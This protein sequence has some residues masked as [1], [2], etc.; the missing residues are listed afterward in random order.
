MGKSL[1][2]TLLCFL[3]IPCSFFQKHNVLQHPIL[4]HLP[5]S[6]SSIFSNMIISNTYRI[7]PSRMVSPRLAFILVPPLARWPGHSASSGSPERWDF[8]GWK[9]FFQSY[10]QTFTSLLAWGLAFILVGPRIRD[11]W[12]WDS[13]SNRRGPIKFSKVNNTENQESN[14]QR[15]SPIHIL[16]VL[17]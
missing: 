13:L 9:K 14:I 1:K 2:K 3:N 16:T 15:V 4:C 17:P 7:C 5:D 12:I 8:F 6:L 10:N 11:S